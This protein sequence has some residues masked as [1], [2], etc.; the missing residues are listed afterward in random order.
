MCFFSRSKKTCWGGDQLLFLGPNSFFHWEGPQKLFLGGPKNIYIFC[1]PPRPAHTCKKWRPAVSKIV[2]SWFS[3]YMTVNH[4]LNKITLLFQF[5]A[6]LSQVHFGIFFHAVGQFW[7][8]SQA[9]P[10]YISPPLPWCPA[11]P[12]L[13]ARHVRSLQWWVTV[14]QHYQTTHKETQLST[15]CP[16]E[17]IWRCNL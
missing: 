7:D 15:Q 11:P 4:K 16:Q 13:S 17:D 10:C 5:T 1:L 9:C 6:I 14:T 12:P 2:D 8:F 3:W